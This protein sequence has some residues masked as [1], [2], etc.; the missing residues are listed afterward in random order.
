MKRV[1]S[2]FLVLILLLALCSCNKVEEQTIEESVAPIEKVPIT[3]EPE[4]P[5]FQI[6]EIEIISEGQNLINVEKAELSGDNP[7]LYKPSD[8]YGKLY[9][10]IGGYADW[11][12][13]PYGGALYGLTDKNG[14]IALPA[15]AMDIWVYDVG[16]TNFY[17]LTMHVSQERF[18]ELANLGKGSVSRHLL[19][20]EDGRKYIEFDIA[21]NIQVMDDHIAVAYDNSQYSNKE[22]IIDIY[23]T[24]LNLIKRL[25]DGTDI[26]EYSEGLMPVYTYNGGYY[27]N[28]EG[29]NRFSVYDYSY[30]GGFHQ[31]LACVGADKYG[32]IN[33]DGELSIPMD[34]MDAT[35]FLEGG[36][37][38]VNKT[39]RSNQRR[40]QVCN[41]FINKNGEIVHEAPEGKTYYWRSITKD[42]LEQTDGYNISSY[43]FKTFTCPVC[44]KS[45]GESGIVQR[46]Q[47]SKA[48]YYHNECSG[49]RFILYDIEGN[50]ISEHP[51]PNTK[52]KYSYV[53]ENI[54]I[55]KNYQG[56]LSGVILLNSNSVYIAKTNVA[57]YYDDIY[58]FSNILINAKVDKAISSSNLHW[59]EAVNCGYSHI[60]N[61]DGGKSFV[62]D[63]ELNPILQFTW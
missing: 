52:Y 8:N 13:G 34:Y 20:R 15:S 33:V 3:E 32:F 19:V 16:D 59:Q 50:I 60:G 5:S 21:V 25:Y 62:Y 49:D 39:Q 43:D 27:I 38:G 54:A 35:D 14:N 56:E 46:L 51:V 30:L 4:K 6:K 31:G 53:D 47:D 40:G 24:E 41:A 36:H 7:G 2:V 55:A 37:A 44:Q 26:G 23:D 9:P 28:K 10:F 11:A 17:W 45:G 1:I 61:I 57:Y 42:S 48:V 18:D 12:P 22:I 63:E 29:E 58:S